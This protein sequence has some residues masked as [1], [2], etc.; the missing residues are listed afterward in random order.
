[1][2][3]TTIILFEMLFFVVQ[4]NAQHIMLIPTIEKTVTGNQYGS[5]LLWETKGQWGFGGFYQTAWQQTTEGVQTVNP[6]YGI[7]VNAPVMKSDK[8]NF[9]F[10]IRGGVVNQHFLAIAP[11]LETK[12]KISRILGVSALMSVRMTYPSAAL[13]IYVTL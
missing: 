6:F 10:N 4:A 5:Q 11:G 7:T 1:M 3:T 2:K 13:K 12:L 9:Y 8:I